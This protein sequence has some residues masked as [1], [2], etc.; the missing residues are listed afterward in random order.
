[1]NHQ[2]ENPSA[3]GESSDYGN[4]VVEDF[5]VMEH[6][7][8]SLSSQRFKRMCCPFF[9]IMGMK[10]GNRSFSDAE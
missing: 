4:A 9:H 3:T 10:A 2:L 8:T 7:V 1:M 5:L 6:D